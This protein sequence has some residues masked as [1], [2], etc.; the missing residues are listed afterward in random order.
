VADDRFASIEDHAGHLIQRGHGKFERM[1]EQNPHVFTDYRA[2]KG[3]PHRYAPSPSQV[4]VELA[5]GAA[6]AAG[7]VQAPAAALQPGQAPAG[8]EVAAGAAAAAGAAPAAGT[9]LAPQQV[10]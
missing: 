10:V 4:Q 6:L 1:V 8:V 3:P 9:A 5:A 7:A 2:H